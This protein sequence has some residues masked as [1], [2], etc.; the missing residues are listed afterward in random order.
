MQ[1]LTIVTSHNLDE[2]LE[3]LNE[4]N[5]CNW[6]VHE[7][8]L[9]YS[10][11]GI[12]K[13]AVLDT[14]ALIVYDLIN[15]SVLTTFAKNYLNA[16]KDLALEQK[17][18]IF[19][20]FVR[21]NYLKKNEGFSVVAYHLL[22][23]PLKE[24]VKANSFID[25]DGWIKFRCTKYIIILEDI[26]VQTIYDYE[27]T[28]RYVSLIDYFTDVVQSQ[29]CLVDLVHLNCKKDGCIELLDKD[30]VDKTREYMDKYCSEKFPNDAQIEDLIIDILLNISPNELIIHDNE[31]YTNKNFI[32]TVESIF[33]ESVTLCFG[34]NICKS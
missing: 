33:K 6:I 34:C 2:L 31:N 13:E 32:A 4:E 26:M 17:R 24:F 30:H 27:T 16:R 15:W 7:N 19:E 28:N 22:Y 25:F 8:I 5:L 23:M 29:D 21:S 10:Y 18:E 14:L 3:R 1:T 11:D 20:L 9:E 12:D